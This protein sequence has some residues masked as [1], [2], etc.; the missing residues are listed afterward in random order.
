MILSPPSNSYDEFELIRI[1]N[2]VHSITFISITFIYHL[3]VRLQL[4]INISL[5]NSSLAELTEK[6]LSTESNTNTSS[7]KTSTSYT[8]PLVMTPVHPEKIIMD[9]IKF[10]DERNATKLYEVFSRIRVP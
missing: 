8:P 3:P 10:Y 7:K 9:F 1:K 6:H 4:V 5:K 2:R